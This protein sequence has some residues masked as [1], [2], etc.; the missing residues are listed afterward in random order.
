M[1]SSCYPAKPMPLL[2]FPVRQIVETAASRASVWPVAY[3]R[4]HPVQARPDPSAQFL[5]HPGKP[6]FSSAHKR[7]ATGTLEPIAARPDAA[8]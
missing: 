8:E 4:M 2:G 3:T 6:E 5:R 7:T 1:A